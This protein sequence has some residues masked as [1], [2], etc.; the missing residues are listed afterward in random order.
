M[1]ANTDPVGTQGMP[2]SAPPSD[3]LGLIYMGGEN[4]LKRMA[5]LEERRR[6]HDAA[7]VKLRVGTDAQAAYEDAKAK[8]DEA[9]AMHA[10]ASHVL[11]AAKRD[12]EAT[13]KEANEKAAKLVSDAQSEASA[14]G[15]EADA[16]KRKAERYAELT[17]EKAKA[18]L[19]SAIERERIAT[20]AHADLQRAEQMHKDAE[21]RHVTSA[22]KAKARE[23]ELTGKIAALQ[24]AIRHIAGG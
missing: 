1:A 19:E 15:T 13:L 18:A 20:I 8:L 24:E 11:D 7:F 9:R 14:I 2:K 12:A 22:E 10:E 6:E 21:S 4:F 17:T 16:V 23:E 3:D 5:A